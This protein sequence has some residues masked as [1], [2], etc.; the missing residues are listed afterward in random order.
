MN[1]RDKIYNA[2]CRKAEYEQSDPERKKQWK[3]VYRRL[4]YALHREE[5]LKKAKERR[6]SH[7]LTPEQKAA[8]AAYA[9]KRY[10]ENKEAIYAANRKWRRNNCDKVL[11]QNK[12]KYERWKAKVTDEEKERIRAYHR[13]YMREYRKMQLPMD[14]RRDNESD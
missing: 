10:R 5:I 8:K 13:E 11:A 2:E 6:D 9:R 14:Q 12:R 1:L 4:Y 7:P 3:K